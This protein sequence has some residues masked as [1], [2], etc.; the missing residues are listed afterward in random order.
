M[1]ISVPNEIGLIFILKFLFKRFFNMQP[2][3][4]TFMEIINQC[5]GRVKKVNRNNHKGFSW[6]ELIKI[7]KKDFQIVSLEG[8]PF[9]F[10][11]KSLN[12]G[13]GIVLKNKT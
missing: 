1:F 13:I 6:I 5:L 2:D 7:L 4:Y 10:L 11:P 8:I 12:I 3:Q 9:A